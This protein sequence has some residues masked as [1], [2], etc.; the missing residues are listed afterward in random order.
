MHRMENDIKTILEKLTGLETNVSDIRGT[1]LNVEQKVYGV[2]QKV[3]Q[4]EQK[5]DQLEQK[6]DRLE[7]KLADNWLQVLR[8][9]L[10]S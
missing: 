8:I 5:V 9:G 6:L 2:E 1:L 3:G 10:I 4:L 7:Q